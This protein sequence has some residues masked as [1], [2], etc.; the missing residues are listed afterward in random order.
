MT[1]K[2]RTGTRSA[3]DAD[4]L[5]IRGH[6][7][8][9]LY[10]E[11]R[12]VKAAGESANLITQ[13]GDQVYSDRGAGIAG[14]AAAATG[15]KLGTGTT[16]VAKTGGGAQLAVYLPNSQHAFDGGFPASSLNAPARRVTYQCT[17]AANQATSVGVPITEA[18]IVNDALANA[19]ALAAVTIARVLVSPVVPTKE[20]TDVLVMTWTHDALGQ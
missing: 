17:Y 5:V 18:V 15:M 6:L 1:E 9:V 3:A 4:R 20:A 8:W 7:S 2:P 10:D 16:A 14:A 11:H 12:Q 13:V 19:N